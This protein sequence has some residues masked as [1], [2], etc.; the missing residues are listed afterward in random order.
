M[1]GSPVQDTLTGAGRFPQ[2]PTVKEDTCCESG[3]CFKSFG[4][5]DLNGYTTPS[6]TVPEPSYVSLCLLLCSCRSDWDGFI[7]GQTVT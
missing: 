4:N 3:N 7:L 2:R 6:V 1:S 5:E